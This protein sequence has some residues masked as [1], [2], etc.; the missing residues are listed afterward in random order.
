[1][2]QA[3]SCLGLSYKFNWPLNLIFTEMA[4]SKYNAV[5]DYMLSLQRVTWHLERVWIALKFKSSVIKGHEY[6]QV[7]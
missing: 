6:T 3:L 5:F 1:M 7:L 2:F 4:I